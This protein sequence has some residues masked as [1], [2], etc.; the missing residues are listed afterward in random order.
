M[1]SYTHQGILILGI[2][3]IK[4]IRFFDESLRINWLT[5]NPDTGAAFRKSL[6][7]TDAGN[8]GI[9]LAETNSAKL[10]SAIN[11]VP[12]GLPSLT[13]KPISN[14]QSVSNLQKCVG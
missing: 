10:V 11:P 14:L 5:A 12:L 13:C 3:G 6:L 1:V 4:E 9:G 7:T 8:N 2:R